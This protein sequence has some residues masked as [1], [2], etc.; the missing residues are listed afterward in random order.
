MEPDSEEAVT[1]FK[2]VALQIHAGDTN[3]EIRD[4]Y[5]TG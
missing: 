2:P 4:M 3:S 5:M 1:A